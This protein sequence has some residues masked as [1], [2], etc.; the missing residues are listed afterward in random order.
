MQAVKLVKQG[1]IARLRSAPKTHATWSKI[2]AVM[3]VAVAAFGLFIAFLAWVA[4]GNGSRPIC[5]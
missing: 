3:V 5:I 2:L 4:T 1:Q